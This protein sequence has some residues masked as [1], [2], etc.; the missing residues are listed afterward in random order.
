MVVALPTCLTTLSS[1]GQLEPPPMQGLGLVTHCHVP[2]EGHVPFFK[3]VLV[4]H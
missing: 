1:S 3:L 4:E 2:P